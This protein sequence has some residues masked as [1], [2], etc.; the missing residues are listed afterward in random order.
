MGYETLLKMDFFSANSELHDWHLGTRPLTDWFTFASHSRRQ[1]HQQ[2]Y[3]IIF[4]QNTAMH[5]KVPTYTEGQELALK[6][7]WCITQLAAAAAHDVFVMVYS[8]LDD[9]NHGSKTIKDYCNQLGMFEVYTSLKQDGFPDNILK[10]SPNKALLYDLKITRKLMENLKADKVKDAVIK[11][12]LEVIKQLV[13]SRNALCHNQLQSLSIDDFRKNIVQLKAY[14]RTLYTLAGT[15]SSN[16]T[17]TDSSLLFFTDHLDALFAQCEL[18]TRPPTEIKLFYFNEK[19]STD[20]KSIQA[21]TGN[22]TDDKS[23]QASTGNAT[24]DKSVQASTGNATDDKSIQASTG[25]TTDDKSVQ[26]SAGNT[27]VDKSVQVEQ[28]SYDNDQIAH[29]GAPN[30]SVQHAML[31]IIKSILTILWND[32]MSTRIK[33]LCWVV[34]GLTLTALL[35]ISSLAFTTLLY[36]SIM[37]KEIIK[38]LFRLGLRLCM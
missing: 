32:P 13:F 6:Y 37:V 8:S 28:G 14:L 33:V 25:N 20:D 27:T 11:E 10:V 22:I 34:L 21:S 16:E 7:M 15:I 23:V 38:T 12:L 18:H 24:A 1:C 17:S 31:L 29:P 5:R 4:R 3:G 35:L 30:T 2:A 9:T 36:I 19:P 26:A